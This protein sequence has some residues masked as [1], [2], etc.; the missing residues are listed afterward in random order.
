MGRAL[1][2][3][4]SATRALSR[5]GEGWGAG[6][7]LSGTVSTLTLSLSRT[8]EGTRASAGDGSGSCKPAR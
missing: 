4:G 8:G 1:T 2:R 5:A 3:A 6:C 7:D